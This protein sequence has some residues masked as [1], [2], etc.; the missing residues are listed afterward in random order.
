MTDVSPT[1]ILFMSKYAKKLNILL[2]RIPEDR[3]LGLQVQQANEKESMRILLF[4]PR[5]LFFLG[6]RGVYF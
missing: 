4:D 2:I 6:G 3:K 5:K 1:H